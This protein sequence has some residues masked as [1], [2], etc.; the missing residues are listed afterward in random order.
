M[1]FV[2][3]YE[4][5]LE[6]SCYLVRLYGGQMNYMKLIKLLYIAERELLA[7]IATPLTGDTYKALDNGPVLS[8]VLDQIK[9]RSG[10]D[11]T[12]QDYLQTA[13]Y[14]VHLRVD[15]G[16]KNLSKAIEVKL[17]EVA[18]RYRFYDQYQMVDITHEFP[19]WAE[20]RPQA[21][22]SRLI[23]PEAVVAAMGRSP[24]FADHVDE[25]ESQ[26]QL[27]ASIFDEVNDEDD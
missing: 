20:Y 12:W 18:E 27:M 19:E 9:R 17:Q 26:R 13:R 10:T 24:E 16:V 21:G 6:A 14:D 1:N 3:H 7:E 11:R 8:R 25:L 5:A 22:R 15:P 23:P 4:R 2:F